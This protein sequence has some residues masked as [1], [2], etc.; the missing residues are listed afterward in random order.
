[1]T[2]YTTELNG[3]TLLLRTPTEDDAQ[4]MVDLFKLVNGETPYLMREPE[5]ADL[6]F[7]EEAAFIRSL[8]D[9]EANVML[10]AFYDGAYIGNCSLMGSGLSRSRHRATLGIA[11]LQKYTGLGIGRIMIERL[12]ALGR[13]MG[14]E[15]IELDVVTTN[16]RA[17]SLYMKLGFEVCGMLP[18]S[19]KYRDGSYAGEYRMVKTL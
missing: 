14:L 12:F 1:M 13:E 9:S 15:Q 16:T 7:E 10:L 4:I 18:H 19:M 17:I 5:E 8:N 11:L 2:T 6:P 3:H